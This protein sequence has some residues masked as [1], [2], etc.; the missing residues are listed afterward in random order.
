MRLVLPH[1]GQPIGEPGF[2]ELDADDYHADPASEPSLSASLASTLIEET[3]AHAWA[4]HPKLG[5]EP[6]GDEKGAARLDLGTVVHTLILGKGRDV[7]A[8]DADSFLTKAAKQARDDA[9]AA[10]KTPVLLKELARAEMIAD[11][12]RAFVALAPGC[13]QAFSPEHGRPEVAMVW[14]DATGAMCRSLVDWMPNDRRVLWDIKTTARSAN[15]AGAGRLIANHGYELQAAFY[16]RGL[17]HLEPELAGRVRFRWL[18]VEIEPPFACSVIEMDGLGL[19]VGRRK[20]SAALDLWNR[21]RA[22]DLWPA[23]PP[24]VCVA[25]YPQFAADRW[26]EREM[27][28]AEQHGAVVDAWSDR[29]HHGAATRRADQSFAEIAP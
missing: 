15:P 5:Y 8:I 29:T 12:A 20:V 3:P 23:Y 25:D 6:D 13:E 22:A 7:V 17:V 4:A 26:A 9:R 14:R 18:F 21:C 2:Y 16:E 19:S 1:D 10:G 28:D 24:R 27:R 11:A